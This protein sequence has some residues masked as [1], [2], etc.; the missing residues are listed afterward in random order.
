MVLVKRCFGRVPCREKPCMI[1]LASRSPRRKAIL[2]SLG[3]SFRVLVP[4]YKEKKYTTLSP[5][6]LV[7]RHAL[8]KA[9]SV[10]GKISSGVVIGA[11]TVVVCRGKIF[12]KPRDRKAAFGMLTTLQG[13]PHAVYTGV[14]LVAVFSSRVRKK[15]VFA[16]KTRVT[17]KK[18]SPKEIADYFTK[19]NPLD[20]AG[21]YAAQ[22]KRHGIVE[23]VRGS[24]SNVVG[25][26]VEKFC[27]KLKKLVLRKT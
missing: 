18:M 4:N 25:L 15:I 6:L 17:L 21:A 2:K 16:E 8:A 19:V 9:L 10:A 7:K 23:A 14:A 20:K 5:A 26:P 1:Y 12:G 3:L 22:S 13:R 11:D 27:V 24:Y